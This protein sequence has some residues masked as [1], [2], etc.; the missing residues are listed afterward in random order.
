M[1]AKGVRAPINHPAIRFQPARARVV[2]LSRFFATTS[3]FTMT[4]LAPAAE[5]VSASATNGQRA[6][7]D[8]ADDQAHGV[9]PC[10]ALLRAR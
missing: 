9:P 8:D 5:T 2:T 6:A 7:D 3:Q 1:G 4:G 10:C